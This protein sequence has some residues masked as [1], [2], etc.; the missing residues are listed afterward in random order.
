MAEYVDFHYTPLEG[1]ITGKQVLKQTE[2]A[3]NDLGNRVYDAEV[4]SEDVQ[5]ALDNSQ[6]AINIANDALAAVTTDKAVWFNNVADMKTANLVNGNVAATKGYTLYNDGNGA[7]YAI[8][9]KKGGDVDDGV[10]IIFLDNGSVAERINEFNLIAQKN[11]IYVVNIAELKASDGKIGS[12]YRTLGY[13]TANDGGAG[14]YSI[15]TK[16]QSDVDDG[17][18]IIF[19]ANGNVAEKIKT[20]AEILSG[21]IDEIDLNRS[22]WMLFRQFESYTAT[23]GMCVAGNFLIET[24]YK[25]GETDGRLYVID[26]DNKAVVGYIAGV[27]GHMNSICYDADNK[28]VC[29]ADSGG[30]IHRYSLS[31]AGDIAYV[32]D[33][34]API[35]VTGIGWNNGLFYLRTGNRIVVAKDITTEIRRF[36]VAEGMR[37]SEITRQG[38]DVDDYFIY[39]PYSGK[40]SVERL[41]IY[42]KEDGKLLKVL[43]YP[44]GTYGEFEE[45]AIRNGYLFININRPFN[46]SM[47]GVFKIPLYKSTVNELDVARAHHS[48]QQNQDRQDYYVDTTQDIAFPDGTQEHPYNVLSAAITLY[49]HN[50]SVGT[51]YIVEGQELTSCYI[52]DCKNVRIDF[53]NCKVSGR[54]TVTRSVATLLNVNAKQ[55]YIEQSFVNVVGGTIDWSYDGTITVNNPIVNYRSVITGHISNLKNCEVETVGGNNGLT[56]ISILNFTDADVKYTPVS[57]NNMVN[58]NGTWYERWYNIPANSNLNDINKIGRKYYCSATNAATLTNCPTTVNFVLENFIRSNENAVIQQ[59]TTV[60]GETFTR[61]LGSGTWYR[62]QRIRTGTTAKRP[63]DVTIGLQYFDTT[64]G[65]PIWWNGTAWVDATGT[66]V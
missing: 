45:C 10:D 35:S 26:I 23:Q 14:L 48:Y 19:L 54:I 44:R 39:M 34:T 31:D 8:R 43:T 32:D 58:I 40:D 42:D 5:E 46:S 4:T 65:K 13:Y 50:A 30:V 21:M 56:A 12:V 1:R 37:D 2:D 36:Y 64:L 6:Q 61:Q 11:I 18:S 24:A 7:F 16:T 51:I 57:N 22:P 47:L 66:V 15:R 49:N 59:I 33:V 55:L 60:Q 62:V 3:I 53:Q 41:H 63:T 25:S 9:Q 27:Q 28:M 17:G 29:V 38:M 52:A 20:N